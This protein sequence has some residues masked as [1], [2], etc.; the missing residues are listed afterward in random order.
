[1]VKF[2]CW[3]ALTSGI[4]L[5]AQGQSGELPP[6]NLDPPPQSQ[7]APPNEPSQQKPVEAPKSSIFDMVDLSDPKFYAKLGVLLGSLLLARK[8][9]RQ[10][11][12][13]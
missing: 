7:Q 9:F 4:A 8:A 12:S 6:S 11:K 13:H 10:M 1:M 2:G 5:Y 3:L